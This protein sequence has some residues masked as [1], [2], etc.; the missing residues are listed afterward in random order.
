M[1]GKIDKGMPTKVSFRDFSFLLTYFLIVAWF[2][3]NS[4][5]ALLLNLP[6]LGFLGLIKITTVILCVFNSF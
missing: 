1:H 2:I 6:I 5:V 4:E 3:L